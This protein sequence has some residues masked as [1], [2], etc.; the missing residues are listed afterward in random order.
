MK[1]SLLA[2]SKPKGV[3]SSWGNFRFWGLEK[4]FAQFFHNPP[5]KPWGYLPERKKGT[6]VRGIPYPALTLQFDPPNPTPSLQWPFAQD[7]AYSWFWGL[8]T[9]IAQILTPLA[10]ILDHFWTFFLA[11][12]RKYHGVGGHQKAF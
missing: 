1:Q 9:P 12:S 2:P 5:P 4:N 6:L 8:L 3:G 11:I 7:V 10:Q